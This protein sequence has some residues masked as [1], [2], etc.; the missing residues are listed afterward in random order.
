MIHPLIQA[1]H[2]LL[3]PLGRYIGA[4]HR[5]D[6]W[7]LCETL[8]SLFLKVDL[9]GHNVYT[10]NQTPCSTRYD[11]TYTYSH[12]NTGPCSESRQATITNWLGCTIKLHSFSP[13][14]S[15]LHVQS[16]NRLLATLASWE[17]QSLWKHLRIDGGTGDWIFSRLMQGLLVIGHDGSYM[18]HLANNV[19]AYAAVFHCSRTNQYADITWV[20]NS[21]KKAANNYHA[22]ILG[23]CCSQLII[24]AAI[25]G[26][27]VLGHGP[28]TMGCN[29]MGVVQHGNSHRRPIL[30]KQPQSYV[31][32]YF[33]GLMALSRVGGWMQHVYGHADKYLSEAEM[34]PAQQINFRADKLATAALFAVVEA[35][36]L[37]SSIFLLE[38]N[39]HKDCPGMGY[40][41]PKM[42]SQSFV[43]NRWCRYCMTD[44]GW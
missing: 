28:L 12:H 21:T 36:E 27:N 1:G 13:S 43:E 26:P 24:K 41:V 4:P 44:G 31:V 10:L 14:W 38:K 35:N 40:G 19:C 22:K 20:E 3:R 33:K 37:I 30:E 17:K 42:R 15:P 18:P 2:R 34:S 23:G 8:G 7:F 16:P 25:T 5:Q 39:L 29:N 6:V 11:T 9:G 32:R